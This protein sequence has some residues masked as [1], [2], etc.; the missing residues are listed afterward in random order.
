MIDT[1][2]HCTI[3]DAIANG[4]VVIDVQRRILAW[5]QWMEMHSGVGEERAVGRKLEEVMPEVLGTRLDHAINSA[6]SHRLSSIVSPSLH[7]SPLSLYKNAADREHNVRMQQFIHVTPI[8]QG[9]LAGC[10]LQIQDV[11]AAIKRENLLRDQSA[12]LAA[13]NLQLNAQLEEIQ[14]LQAQIAIRDSQDALTG[15]LNRKHL[16]KLV[17]SSLRH[18]GVQSLVLISIDHLKRIIDTHGLGASDAVIQMLARVLKKHLPKDACIGRFESDEF[19]I[20]LPETS[21]AQIKG[22][23]TRWRDAFAKSPVYFGNVP[24]SATFSAGAAEFPRHGKVFSTLQECLDLA[25]FIAKGE[26]GNITITY[27]EALSGDI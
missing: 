12:D 27:D 14:A 9:A 11:T 16:D 4:I 24:V 22:L 3:L 8:R 17:A 13:R 26:G 19:L 10:T 25:V 18:G 21:P 23:V 2:L 15:V 6:L 5:N 7:K 1:C 20:L